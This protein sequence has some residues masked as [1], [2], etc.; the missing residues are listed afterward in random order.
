[1]LLDRAVALFLGQAHATPPWRTSWVLGKHKNISSAKVKKIRPYL[2]S[3]ISD[4][5]LGVR[6]SLESVNAPTLPRGHDLS[7][8]GALAN[9]H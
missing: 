3:Q 4:R 7:L 5:R 6:N 8:Q 2:E 1:M 9:A